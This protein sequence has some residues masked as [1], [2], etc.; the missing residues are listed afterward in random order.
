MVMTGGWF[1][2]VLPTLQNR[3]VS[4]VETNLPTPYLPLC[5]LGGWFCHGEFIGE[6][7]GY[8]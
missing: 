3:A 2:I 7:V 8:S 5:E 6:M 4:T 1:M